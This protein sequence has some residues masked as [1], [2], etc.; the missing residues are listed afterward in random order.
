MSRLNPILAASAQSTEAYQ[1]AIAQSS[2]MDGLRNQGRYFIR[3]SY[4]PVPFSG[5]MMPL[6]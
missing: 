3:C 6:A 2:A 4:S 5:F 1:Q